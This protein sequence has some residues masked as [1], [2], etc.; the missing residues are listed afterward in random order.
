MSII[1]IGK[2]KANTKKDWMAERSEAPDAVQSEERRASSRHGAAVGEVWGKSEMYWGIE[3]S[4]SCFYFSFSY[5]I[6]AKIL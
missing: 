5:E 6:G 1:R 2:F 4:F 3:T